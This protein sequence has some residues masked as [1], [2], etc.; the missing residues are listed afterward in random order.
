MKT[1]YYN[2]TEL[3]FLAKLLY[4]DY[5]REE[6]LRRTDKSHVHVHWGQLA[7]DIVD[8]FELSGVERCRC[9]DKAASLYEDDPELVE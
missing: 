5:K 2:Q 9:S 8:V 4:F 7:G 1:F 3:D 6:I